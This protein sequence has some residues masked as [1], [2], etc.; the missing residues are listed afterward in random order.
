MAEQDEQRNQLKNKL[1]LRQRAYLLTFDKK[2]LTA[3]DVLDDLAAFCR[4]N[5]S[6]FHQDP[7]VHAVLEGRREVFLRIMDHIGMDSQ[8]FFDKYTQKPKGA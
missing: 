7:R 4:G 8:E 1:L 6:T 3:R 2:S 5:E